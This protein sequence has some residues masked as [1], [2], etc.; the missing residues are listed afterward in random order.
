MS[1]LHL[2]MRKAQNSI[3]YFTQTEQARAYSISGVE[4]C[5]QSAVDQLRRRKIKLIEG[6]AKCRHLKID[7]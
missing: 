3:S 1:M 7:L 2:K 4:S 5:Y 6:N